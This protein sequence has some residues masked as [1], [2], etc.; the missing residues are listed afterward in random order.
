MRS[1]F[2][3]RGAFTLAASLLVTSSVSFA[4]PDAMAAASKEQK[5]AVTDSQAAGVT[6]QA[7]DFISDAER[8]QVI[9]KALTEIEAKYVFPEVVKQQLPELRRRWTEGELTKQTKRSVLIRKMN[10]DLSALFHDG[11][12]FVAPPRPGMGG[13]QQ[14]PA[15]LDAY[16][17]KQHYEIRRAEILAGNIGYLR[18]DLF[19]P[20]DLVGFRRALAEAM[21]FVADTDA[22]ILDLRNHHGGDV[23]SVALWVSYFTEQRVHLLDAFDRLTGQTTPSV[24]LSKL[25]GTRYGKDK[26]VY[27]LISRR[28]FSGGEEFAYDLQGMKRGTLVGETSAGAANN[29][30]FIALSPQLVISVPYGHVTS[31]F[32]RSNWEQVGVKP[33]VKTDP[34][35]ALRVAQE[36]ALQVLL[37]KAT[38]REDK[39]A[40]EQALSALRTQAP[41]S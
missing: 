32:T 36:Q 26:P 15:E 39:Q 34:K 16:L 5:P 18:L 10:A 23:R 19:A 1:L 41:A 21:S 33:D 12:L 2:P 9:A 3:S 29:N 6:A 25:E 17:R 38:R 31:S 20:Y 4:G 24:T 27:V 37:Q 28:T 14:S 7:E 13:Q 40:L 22:L 8:Q 35:D 30:M 11:H